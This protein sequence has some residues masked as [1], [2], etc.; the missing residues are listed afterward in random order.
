MVRNEA[1]MIFGSDFRYGHI[2][3]PMNSLL[4]KVLQRELIA[5]GNSETRRH[6]VIVDEYPKLAYGKEVEDFSTFLELG[7][8]MGIRVCLVIQTPEQLIQLHGEHGANVIWGQAQNR[9]ILRVADEAG[10]AYCSK[11]LSR[12]R[13]F[14]WTKQV[15]R[16]WSIGS[17]S[18]SHEGSVS[19]SSGGSDSR[20][21]HWHDVAYVPPEDIMDLPLA[22]YEQPWHGYLSAPGL[23]RTKRC[24]FTVTPQWLSRQMADLGGLVAEGNEIKRT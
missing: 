3:G 7:R 20:S 1:V 10:A 22:S 15:G 16:N 19:S 9:L 21:E 8:S 17:S 14:V 6:Y 23:S 13:G 12:F 2:L 18:N 11:H 5:L 4:M 24:K